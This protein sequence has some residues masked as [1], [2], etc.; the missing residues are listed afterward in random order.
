[1]DKELRKMELEFEIYKIDHILNV[2]RPIA[3]LF[4]IIN[5]LFTIMIFVYTTINIK[6]KIVMGV[7]LI[8]VAICL[9][10]AT[11]KSTK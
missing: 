8:I 2:M 5:I 10:I 7:I 9:L 3:I 11:K 1:M 6:G 4:A